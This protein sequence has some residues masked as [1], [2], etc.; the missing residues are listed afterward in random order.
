MDF[1]KI[2]LVTLYGCNIKLIQDKKHIKQF[3]KE[4]C[5]QINMKPNGKSRVK[6]FG[7]GKLNGI[8]AFQFIETSSI[9]MHFD[10]TENRAFIDIFSCKNFNGKKAEHFSKTYFK[11]KKSALK[12]IIRR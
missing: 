1:G 8:S 4:L 2:A 11:A 10:E 9:S 6:R 12:E 5:R 7:K 3:I